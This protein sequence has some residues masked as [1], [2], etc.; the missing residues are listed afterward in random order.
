MGHKR[1]TM[2]HKTHQA[3]PQHPNTSKRII[4]ISA[5]TKKPLTTSGCALVA[6]IFLTIGTSPA[7]GSVIA[8]DCFDS[9]SAA[10]SFLAD[11]GEGWA[12]GALGIGTSQSPG[13]TGSGQ[14]LLN[15]TYTRLLDLN[16]PAVDAYVVLDPNNNRVLGGPGVVIWTSFYMKAGDATIVTQNAIVGFNRTGGFRTRF[17]NSFTSNVLGVNPGTGNHVAIA[18]SDVSATTHIVARWTY[19]GFSSGRVE[20]WLNPTATAE[21]GLGSAD[22]FTP[23][24]PGFIESFDQIELMRGAQANAMLELDDLIVATTYEETVTA[25]GIPNG[26]PT[27]DA[28]SDQAIRAGEVVYLDG[29]ASFDDDTA[30]EAL[31]FAWSLLSQ[32]AESAATLLDAETAMPSFLADV[33]GSYVVELVVTD[34]EGLAST[35]DQVTIASDN[36]AP[37]AMAGESRLIILGDGVV[38]DGS[39]SMDPE[40][41]PLTFEWTITAAPAGSSAAISGHDL[42]MASLTPDIEGDFDVTLTVSDF[43]GP[44]TPDSITITATSAEEFAEIQIVAAAEVVE[45]L[46]PGEVTNQGNQNAFQN[47]LSQATVALQADDVARAIDK[48]ERAIARTDGCALRGTPDGG[49]PGRDWIT[50]C[51]AQLEIYDSLVA[52]LNGLSAS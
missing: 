10:G 9:Y 24:N 4:G 37:T 39:A 15:P 3:L 22:G 18:G 17:G 42:E 36:L 30:S 5:P 33:A 40:G 19:T 48:L 11:G 23:G 49:G 14:S 35:P 43:L 44:G 50:T 46:E 51:S 47:F 6:G 16:S 1:R 21:A 27:A 26:A 28:G 25:C 12:E 34:D 13:L 41:D 7:G 2:G 31:G 20:V 8:K 52:A 45:A 32:P 29:G 38:L